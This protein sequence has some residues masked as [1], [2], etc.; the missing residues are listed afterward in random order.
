MRIIC[1]SDILKSHERMMAM[2]EILRKEI[3]IASKE[4][5]S[6]R[7][8]EGGKEILLLIH[9]NMSSSRSFD[10]LMETLDEAFTIYAID[11]RGFGNSSY[12]TQISSIKDLSDDIEGFRKALKIDDFH[13]LGWSLG[14]NVAMQYTLDYQDH[15]KTLVLLSSG[16]ASGMPIHKRTFFNLFKTKTLIKTRDEMQDAVSFIETLKRKNNYPML[17]RLLLKAMYTAHKPPKGRLNF[18]VREM[19]MQ[20]NLTDVNM[21]I[22]TFNIT[23]SHNGLVAG[24]NQAK[25]IMVPTFIIHGTKDKIVKKDEAIKIKKAIGDNAVVHMIKRGDHAL[26]VGTLTQLTSLLETIL[27]NS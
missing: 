13:L 17:K 19:S 8:R 7:E 25:D 10:L 16:P 11:L 27:L 14:G 9:G 2:A 4:T 12:F 1:E 15:V 3:R 18:Y 20:R 22:S 23:N 21:A 24:T 26:M 6:Y 5:I